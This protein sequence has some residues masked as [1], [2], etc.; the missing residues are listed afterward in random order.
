MIFDYLDEAWAKELEHGL[1]RY[2]GSLWDSLNDEEEEVVETISE[3]PFCGCSTCEIREILA[4]VVP[5]AIKG[6]IEGKV[7]VNSDKDD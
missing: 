4:Y 7:I 2:L 1:E 3:E 5:K 6:M